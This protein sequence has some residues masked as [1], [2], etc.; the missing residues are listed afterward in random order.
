MDEIQKSENFEYKG[1]DSVFCCLG[2]QTKRG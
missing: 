1:F 2:S